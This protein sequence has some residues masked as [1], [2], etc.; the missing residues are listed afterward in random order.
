MKYSEAV[1]PIIESFTD[2]LVVSSCGFTSRALYAVKDRAEN[3]YIMGAMGSTLGIAIGLALNLPRRKVVA[4]CGDGELLMSL[5][6]VALMK[7]LDLPNLF[8]H[9]FVNSIYA[10]TGG[11]PIVFVD[12]SALAGH[13]CDVHVISENEDLPRI[14]ISPKVIAQRFRD[15]I[16]L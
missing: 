2:E 8:L 4:L 13:N 15:A 1:Q 12:Y 7:E 14:P 11:Q 9:V 16:S 5:G 6:T 10:S 3:F